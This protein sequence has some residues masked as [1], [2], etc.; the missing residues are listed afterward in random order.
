MTKTG[1]SIEVISD[2]VSFKN[3][4]PQE[5]MGLNEQARLQNEANGIVQLPDTPFEG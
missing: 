5:I 3:K 2:I 4:T 1:A